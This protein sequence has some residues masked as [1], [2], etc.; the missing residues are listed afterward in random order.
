MPPWCIILYICTPWFIG[1]F[2]R[3][4]R[5][6]AQERRKRVNKVDKCAK[7]GEE[8]GGFRPVLP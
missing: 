7:S 6:E 8:E 1:G 3:K 2:G 4:E 5:K